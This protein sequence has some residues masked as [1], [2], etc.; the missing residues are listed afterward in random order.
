MIYTEKNT[1]F[2]S[3]LSQANSW[4]INEIIKLVKK[5][6]NPFDGLNELEQSEDVSMLK[7]I[8]IDLP[9]KID[10]YKSIINRL[11]ENNG[12]EC[13]ELSINSFNDYCGIDIIAFIHGLYSS[14]YK[15]ENIKSI[16][17]FY[18]KSESLQRAL[19][20]CKLL[21]PD[22][23]VK[24][25]N[26]SIEDIIDETT[27]DSLLTINLFPHTLK[28]N[29]NIKKTIAN[30]ITKSHLI[31]SHSIFLENIDYSDNIT[32][33]DCSFYWQDL[34][35]C[36]F[37]KNDSRNFI[38][39]PK[40]VNDSRKIIFSIFSNTS[41]NDLDIK[42]DYKIVLPNLCPGISNKKLFNEKQR[43]LFFDRPFENM[44]ETLSC[45]NNSEIIHIGLN[46]DINHFGEPISY[47][48]REMIA[49]FPQYEIEEGLKRNEGWAKIVYKHYYEAAKRGNY[50]CYNCLAVIEA[51]LNDLSPDFMDI[52]S[53]SNKKIIDL[54][55]NAIKGN[56]INA[57]INLA[58]FYMAR[59]IYNEGIKYYELA[60]SQK[61]DIGAYSMGI[62]YNHGLYGYIKDLSKA[63]SLYKS[64]LNYHLA[65]DNVN[66][67]LAFPESDC[68]MN[69]ILL[70]Y[71]EQYTLSDIYKEYIKVNSPSQ[72]LVY[73]FTVI[74]NNLSNKAKDAFKIL[75]LKNELGE[76][77]SYIKYNRLIALYNGVRIGNDEL[78]SN[79]ELALKLL[80]ELADSQCPDWPEWEQYIWCTLANW[81]DNMETSSAK[82]C[83]YWIKAGSATPDK[84]CAFQTNIALT[85]QLSADENKNIWHRY[86]FGEGCSSCHECTNYNTIYRCCP[87]AQFV[88]ARNYE[89]DKQIS[90][91]LIKASANQEFLSALEYLSIYNIIEKYAPD[92]R[93]TSFDNISLKFGFLSQN[94]KKIINLYN[95]SQNR[96]LLN[97][98]VNLGSKKAASILA[99]IAEIEKE[100]YELY[101]LRGVLPQILKKY[102]L[103]KQISGK[104][105]D[106]DYFQPA[107]LVEYDLLQ[108]ANLIAEQYIG[109]DQAFNYVKSLAEF[110]VKGENYSKAISLYKI[111]EEKGNDV[112]D[113]I[114]FLEDA[115]EEQTRAFNSYFYDRDYD[116]DN[117]DYKRETWDA[118]TD[119]MYGDMPED[120]DGN[121]DFLGQ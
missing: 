69:L 89:T 67:Y 68:C 84:I 40:A 94:F 2:S 111:A 99:E 120:F 108:T 49:K 12:M 65:K 105:L 60:Y 16:R 90:L 103:L 100:T 26:K 75:M 3:L 116:Y 39:K 115:L 51:L 20:L 45:Y 71:K 25:F 43:S 24:A 106:E 4:D 88:W 46:N 41:I 30:L 48:L 64:A 81:Y 73:A 119:G 117:Y 56:D 97:D 33:I 118:M 76:G 92:F 101:F 50:A 70:M 38:Y 59:G 102:E 11:Y 87:K 77:A 86:A 96:K 98:A 37:V 22:I 21:F 8:A 63:I 42:H 61:S 107:T 29:K 1:Y 57:L 5:L 110:Y 109:G 15:L 113:R 95:N 79:K 78:K 35:I 85:K 23:K 52:N 7:Y 9:Y 104:S 19:L 114:S 53:D 55:K 74:C 112:A 83:A 44:E 72:A 121:Y 36:R 91:Y 58:S 28:I 66:S 18:N 13:G 32:S 17:L 6:L 54:L 10:C 31:Y 47:T 62:I 82:S 93:F 34:N 14:G 80:E 27:C